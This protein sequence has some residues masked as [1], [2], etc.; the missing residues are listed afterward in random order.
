MNASLLNNNAIPTAVRGTYFI[1]WLPSITG[2]AKFATRVDP[3]RCHGLDCE[4]ILLP[5]GVEQIRFLQK[6]LNETM[7]NTNRYSNA[8]A[9][10]THDAPA[11]HLEFSPAPESFIFNQTEDCLLTGE[12]NNQ[13]LYTCVS[14]HR[15]AIVAGQTASIIT[16]Y[17]ANN[18]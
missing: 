13:G 3:L 12:H 14:Q 7:L 4:A 16:D 6:T 1:A 2:V 9:L 11:V 8:D 10:V 15:D 5:G 18:W 17:A